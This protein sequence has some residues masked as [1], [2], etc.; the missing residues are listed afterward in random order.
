MVYGFGVARASTSEFIDLT[1]E[2]DITGRTY[3][4]P[5]HNNEEDDT[6]GLGSREPT[7]DPT[8][9]D[10]E[11]DDIPEYLTVGF[12][13]PAGCRYLA[14]ATCQ[15]GYI[16]TPGACVIYNDGDLSRRDFCVKHIIQK[17]STG[18]I[19]LLG[20]RLMRPQDVDFKLSPE[21]GQPLCRYFPQQRNELVA[22]LRAEADQLGTLHD[23]TYLDSIPL[24]QVGLVH[25]VIFTNRDFPAFSYLEAGMSV[26]THTD[27]E[28]DT[29][30][31]VCRWKYVEEVDGRRRKVVGRQMAHLDYDEC[32]PGKGIPNVLKSREFHASGTQQ[33]AKV[34]L[35]TGSR[36]EVAVTGEGT[37]GKKRAR[38]EN[39]IDLTA[40]DEIVKEEISE[41]STIRTSK[42]RMRSVGSGERAVSVVEEERITRTSI[43]ASMS[44]RKRSLLDT[45]AL[46]LLPRNIRI[47]CRGKIY[48]YSDLLAGGGCMTRAAK[49]RGLDV[50][51]V[52][53]KWAIACES[54]RENFPE[55]GTATYEMDIYDLVKNSQAL[56]D[57]D[58]DIIHFS[59]PCQGHSGMNRGQNP[60]R[61][62]VNNAVAYGT[63]AGILAKNKKVRRVTLEQTPNIQNKEG[64][65]HLRTL[66]LQLTSA[67]YNVRVKVLNSLEYGVPSGRKRI[68]ILASW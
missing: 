4:T 64:G 25:T 54:L 63:L 36:V 66:I 65:Q 11:D 43:T 41:T 49:N 10:I 61:D 15:S 14:S 47:R 22:V 42:R 58:T 29:Q 62:A 3:L 23:D 2:P 20:F 56:M 9:E 28:I 39:V 5:Q 1:D 52:L 13:L 33:P 32:D 17:D 26:K 59:P 30:S 24:A 38:E 8:D 53:D 31:P 7:V 21:T 51:A 27:A 50:R 67:N 18:T 44:G 19:D 12:A 60:E 16:V 34:L 68:I 48:T 55:P 37:K 35:S 46:P 6:A 45:P 40:D 57:F